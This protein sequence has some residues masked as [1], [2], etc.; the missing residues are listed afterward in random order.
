L[1]ACQE[2]G[3]KHDDQLAAALP[4]AQQKAACERAHR[5]NSN[6]CERLAYD[7][8]IDIPRVQV[9]IYSKYQTKLQDL[10]CYHVTLQQHVPPL[11][12]AV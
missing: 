9:K 10:C 2:A 7:V 5:T 8:S 3:D 4:D 1:H 12:V 6:H 11:Q